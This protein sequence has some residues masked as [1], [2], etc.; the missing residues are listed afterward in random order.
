[1][2]FKAQWGIGV[3]PRCAHYGFPLNRVVVE[4]ELLNS[5]WSCQFDRLNREPAR[6]PVR[7][8]TKTQW[9]KR[10]SQIRG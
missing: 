2:H 9:G 6:S 10:P 3:R 7:V 8:N 4:A 1:M 5:D